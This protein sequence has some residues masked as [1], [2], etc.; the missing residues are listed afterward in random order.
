MMYFLSPMQMVFLGKLDP[1]D[2]WL[3]FQRNSKFLPVDYL[4]VVTSF[5]YKSF[6]VS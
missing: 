5:T 6:E 3:S 4:M 1:F 2:K